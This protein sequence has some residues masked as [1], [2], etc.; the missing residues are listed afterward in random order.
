MI[1]KKRKEKMPIL[2][3]PPLDIIWF[4]KQFD[5]IKT[6]DLV[7]SKNVQAIQTVCDQILTE[8]KKTGTNIISPELEAAITQSSTLTK[9]IDE[10]VP[11]MNVPPGKPPGGSMQPE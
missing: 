11:D 3:R 9:K 6:R 4:Q 1:K 5:E 7:L 10:K 2:H 8:V